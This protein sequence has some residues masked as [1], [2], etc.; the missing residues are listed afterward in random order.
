[1]SKEQ[2]TPAPADLEAYKAFQDALSA[3]LAFPETT[4][5]PGFVTL[6]IKQ[7]IHDNSG[8]EIPAQLHFM[9]ENG[10]LYAMTIEG[11]TETGLKGQLVRYNSTTGGAFTL[12]NLIGLILADKA[13][14]PLIDAEAARDALNRLSEAAERESREERERSA[15][16]L[17]LFP[18]DELEQ[19]LQEEIL[20]ALPRLKSTLCQTTNLQTA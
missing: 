20:E 2:G 9:N 17:S 11:K 10:A 5:V 1:M 7:P 18:E 13:L 6:E 8:N 16:Q 4:V 14:A 15:A 19:E 3:V 12:S